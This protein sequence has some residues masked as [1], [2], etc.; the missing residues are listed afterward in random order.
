MSVTESAGRMTVFKVGVIVVSDRTNRGE[1]Q[2]TCLPLFEKHLGSDQYRIA[3]T[4]VVS[5]ELGD[6][7][8]ALRL[9]AGETIDCAQAEE[10]HD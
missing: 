10:D 7:Q 6:V 4:V 5:D 2:D 1:L 9:M 8:V 3:D